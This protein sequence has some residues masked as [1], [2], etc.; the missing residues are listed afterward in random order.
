M[1]IVLPTTVSGVV[2]GAV[3][4]HYTGCPRCGERHNPRKSRCEDVQARID[5]VTVGN[6]EGTG[7]LSC[8]AGPKLRPIP[9]AY[10]EDGWELR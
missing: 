9:E 5:G 10:E 2:E 1:T 6:P 4:S 8:H 3:A 7:G